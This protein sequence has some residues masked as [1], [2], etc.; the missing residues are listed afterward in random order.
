[1]VF[2][3]LEV[4]LC[5]LVR[6]MPTLNPAVSNATIQSYKNAGLSDE[7]STLISTTL[8]IM[9]ELP[10][11]CSPAGKLALPYWVILDPLS[12]FFQFPR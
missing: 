8:S 7:A 9:A 6:Q 11:L 1:M 3:V 10:E 4:C 2:A 12:N 5:V